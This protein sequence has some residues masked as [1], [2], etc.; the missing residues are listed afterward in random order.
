MVN[1]MVMLV[2]FYR[3]G[4]GRVCGWIATPP[5]RRSFQGSTTAAG[6]DLPHDLTQFTIERAL[7][8]RD[9]FWGLLAHGAWF[10]SVPGRRP[11][12]EGRAIVRAHH[13]ALVAVEEVV[14]D[15]YLAWKRGDAT[16]LNPALDV[17]FA[18]WLGLAEGERLALEWPVYPLSSSI[19][20]S[21][22]HHPKPRVD[23]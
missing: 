19:L 10:S 4:N 21:R 23:G 8:I 11:T 2:E 20:R 16:P 9:G 12:R 6:R 3:A 13:A 18:R 1:A 7:D 22:V 15:H 17:M 14:N 5:H